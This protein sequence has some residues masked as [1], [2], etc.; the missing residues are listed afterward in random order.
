[1]TTQR[2]VVLVNAGGNGVDN[3]VPDQYQTSG[4]PSGNTFSNAV[5]TSG[6]T[7]PAPQ[8]V[9]QSYAYANSGVGNILSYHLAL[10]DGVYSVRLDFAEP[11]Q[12]EQAGQRVF[13][14]Q[15]QG[16]TMQ[17]GYDIIADAGATLKATA[18]TYTVTV[19][20][21]QGLNLSL[22]N[23]S[24]DPAILSGLEVF[25]ANPNGVANPTV[26]LQLSSDDGGTWTTIATGLSMDR[27]GRG[28]YN[29]TIPTSLT[30]GSQYLLR[31]VADQG[32]QPMGVSNQP[33]LIANN[34]RKYYVNDGSTVGDVYST[35]PG[36]SAN[37]GK[38]PDQP[39]ANLAALL[40]AYTFAQGD[41]IYVDNDTYNL[42]RN[43]ELTPQDSGV[44]IVGPTSGAAV[45]NRGNTDSTRYVFEMDGATGVTINGLTITGAYDGVYASNTAGSTGLTVKSS[46]ITG[47]LQ[48]GVDLEAGNDSATLSDNTVVGS[49]SSSL[50][51]TGLYLA[52]NHD[53]ITGNTI[54]LSYYNG[55]EV[56]SAQDDLVSGN[57]VYQNSTGISVST[58]V[59]ASGTDRVTV[60]GNT[61]DNN[62]TGIY[63]S[64]ALV[65][66]NTVYDQLAANAVGIQS[67]FS[68]VT[69]NLVYTN[70]TGIDA[71][72]GSVYSNRLY[73][74]SSAAIYA[75]NGNTAIYD[76]KMYSN[77]VG[78]ETADGYGGLIDNNLIYAN[79]LDAILLAPTSS[80]T[81]GD[82]EITNNTIYE[83]LGN[84]IDI[85]DTPNSL[86]LRNNILY[87]LAGFAINVGPNNLSG[88]DSDYNDLFVGGTNPNA[89]IGSWNGVAQDSLAACQAASGGDPN[90][91]SADPR[92]LDIAGADNILG[93][94]QVNG[95]FHDGGADDNFY[96]DAG[97]PVINR[98][99]SW[100]APPTDLAGEPRHDDPGTPNAGSPDYF[101]AAQ[102]SSLFAAAGTAQNMAATNTYFDLTLP[103]AFNLYGTSYTQVHVSTEGFLQFDYSGNTGN[104][105]DSNNSDAALTTTR[106]IAPLWSSLISYNQANGDD[107]FVDT[108][109]S[110]KV[111]IRWQATNSADNSPINFDVVLF[112]NEKY[113]LR[114]RRREHEPEP[115]RGTLVRQRA[116]L[117]TSVRL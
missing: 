113:P 90:S 116:S 18:K 29:W 19:S 50:Q 91:L 7:D 15:L 66:G 9:Y 75:V 97:S 71:Q 13:D 23:D 40:A 61:V 24:S 72:G 30:P 59:N 67:S 92:F 65:T 111:T 16:Q 94:S 105:S 73:N 20:G 117:S 114:L 81:P 22:V 42:L 4:S 100:S 21:G 12:H 64:N 52:S 104:P 96:L 37:S 109:V 25:A 102:T 68:D 55:I 43:I 69:G 78:I 82:V 34:G 77:A 85:E 98:G 79:T 88:F 84:A 80:S 5:D 112:Q 49:N 45:F 3:Y 6:V 27:F 60:S 63:A 36:N 62:T 110:G 83:P 51:P 38:S 47:D 48:Y 41:V 57:N 26:H 87:V 44:T 54:S 31:A 10:P 56:Q 95:A 107:V 46:T 1:L 115:D 33:F 103:F 106:G 99:D 89:H 28:S 93:Y 101:P 32:S 11:N 86:K 39:M 76:N 53:T 58:S 74:D 14:I 108:S 70:V 2:P 8:A 35:A 17:S